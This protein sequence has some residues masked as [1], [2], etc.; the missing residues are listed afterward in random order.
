[1]AQSKNVEDTIS[2]KT[3]KQIA[4]EEFREIMKITEGY[5]RILSELAKH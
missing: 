5:R 3:R 1:M 4:D 2:D